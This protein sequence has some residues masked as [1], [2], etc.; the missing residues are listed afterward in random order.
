MAKRIIIVGSGIIGAAAAYRLAKAAAHV[1]A[2]EAGEAGGVATRGSWGNSK[3]YCRVRK[4]DPLLSPYH[5]DRP[6]LT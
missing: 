6:S 3:P 1:S 5:P 4:C 2:R